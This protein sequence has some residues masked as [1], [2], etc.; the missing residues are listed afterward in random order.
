MLIEIRRRLIAVMPSEPEASHIF[1]R[2]PRCR[3]HF[4]ALRHYYYASCFS[5][6]ELKPRYFAATAIV[7]FIIASDMLAAVFRPVTP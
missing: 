5:D 2:Q 7:T 1:I 6:D 4:A 3:R